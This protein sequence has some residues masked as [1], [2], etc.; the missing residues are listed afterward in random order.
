MVKDT[1]FHAG[2]SDFQHIAY[3]TCSDEGVK[4]YSANQW[5]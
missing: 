5:T 2:G 4:I 3:A 1:I